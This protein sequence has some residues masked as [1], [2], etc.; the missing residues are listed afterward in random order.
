MLD[1]KGSPRSLL[2]VVFDASLEV[3]SAVVYATF[4]VA[5]VFLPVL[6]MSGVQG[7][8]FAPLGLA[9]ILATL[10]SLGVALTV[11]PALGMILLARPRE[12][13]EPVYLVWLKD[14]HARCLRWLAARPWLA[15]SGALALC[16][17]AAAALPFFGGEFLPEFQEG[18]LILHM[19]AVAGTSARE[20]MRLGGEVSRA[21]LALPRIQSVA[22]QVGRAELGEDTASTDFSELVVAL[23]PPYTQEAGEEIRREVRQTLASFPGAKFAVKSFLEERIEETISGTTAEVVVRIYGDDLDVLDQKAE[24]VEQLLKKIPGSAE[25][26]FHRSVAPQML[27]RLDRER[28]KQFGFRALEVLEALHIAY[29]GAEVAQVYD[30]NQVIKVAV[31]LEESARQDP[32]SLSG[33]LLGN[34]R[35]QQVPLARLAEVFSGNGRHLI[36]HDGARR[37]QEITCNVIGRDQASFIAAVKAKLA[38][39]VK[40]PAGVYPVLAGAAE[41]QSQARREIL[42]HATAAGVGILLLLGIV[43]RRLA[44]LFL[45]LS[46]LPFALAGGA[47]AVLS[48]GGNL[49]VGS[50]VG[51]VTL[52][53]ITTRNSIMLVSHYEH[54]VAVEGKSWGVETALQGARE[55]LV[56]ILM[57]ALVTALGLLPIALGAG[58]AGREIEGPMAQVILGGLL[59]STLLNLF[60]LP[61]LAWKFGRFTGLREEALEA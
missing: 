54:L 51:F 20:S 16:L 59:T 36:Q 39:E 34:D 52:F 38:Q 43:F 9:Y 53:G 31:I 41:L 19:Q 21:L 47:M 14:L 58:A 3:R 13:R 56:P 42:V 48:T 5:L 32:E 17:G 12:S 61:S 44:N 18:Y 2:S 1:A 24:E 37:Y 27:V 26:Q 30:R 49:S 55:R 4:V 28:L 15:I 57:T 10:A 22:I 33:L 6:T 35:G 11:T 40:F 23:Q 60:I 25:V 50:L 8:L 46:N 7:K 45:V 29:Q